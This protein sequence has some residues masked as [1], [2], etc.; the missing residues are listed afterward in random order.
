MMENTKYVWPGSIFETDEHSAF[1]TPVLFPTHDLYV[2]Q[3]DGK[4]TIEKYQRRNKYI[5]VWYKNKCPRTSY[6]RQC[7]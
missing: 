6:A 7:L 4:L 3:T 1:P 2:K 5:E